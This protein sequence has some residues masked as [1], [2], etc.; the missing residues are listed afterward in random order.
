MIRF[1]V[2]GAGWRSEF[3]IRIAAAL[4]GLFDF[5]GIYIRNEQTAQTFRQKYSV[6]IFSSL[7]ELLDAKPDFVVSCVNKASMCD[8]AKLLCEKGVAVLCETPIG[9]CDEQTDGFLADFKPSWRVQVAEQFH[10]QPRNQAIKAII[11]SGILGDISYVQLSCCHDYHAA[12][13]IRY[14][15]GV[16]DTI[17]SVTQV[18]FASGMTIYNSRAGILDEPY[19]KTATHTIATLDYGDKKAL[20]DFVKEQYFSDIR[21]SRIVIQGSKGEIVD[22][23]CTYLKGS[24]PFTFSLNRVCGGANGNLDGLYL[25]SITAE[26]KVLYKNP[27]GKARLTDEEIAVAHCLVNMAEYLKSGKEFYPVQK[28]AIDAKTAFLF[29]K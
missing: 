7:D 14:F 4:P 15:L 1:G 11:D 12:S 25:D 27:F 26:G 9:I 23:S 2:V 3:Y 21:R 29:H 13:L 6:N 28:A 5:A 8:E 10:L 18:E 16:D 19:E 17:P 22:D 24:Q 20:Y